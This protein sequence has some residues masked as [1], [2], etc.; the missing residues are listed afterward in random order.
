MDD[1]GRVYQKLA[2]DAESA[3]KILAV[4]WTEL[5]EK[6][7]AAAEEAAR[8]R[9]RFSGRRMTVDLV[10]GK[11]YSNAKLV[12]FS[13]DSLRI[14]LHDTGSGRSRFGA[15]DVAVLRRTTNR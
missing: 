10:S 6:R 3:K 8:F 1:E 14:S 15:D 9:D 2:E 11:S 5:K 13:F 7:A 12:D 4:A